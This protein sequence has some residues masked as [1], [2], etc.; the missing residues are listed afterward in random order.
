MSLQIEEKAWDHFCSQCGAFLCLD[1]EDHG[2]VPYR[3]ETRASWLAKEF[4]VEALPVEAKE[5]PCPDCGSTVKHMT[6]AGWRCLNEWH[7]DPEEAS[8]GPMP[9][10]PEP[11]AS[12]QEVGTRLHRQRSI[13]NWC[14]AAFGEEQATS[15]P[16]RGIRLLEEAAEAAQAT[17][18]DLAMAEQ[19]MR[20]V[21]S[22][23]A[24]ALFQELG[25]V[26]VTA[27][28]LAQAAL[29]DADECEA[30]EV[31]RVLSKPLEH[32]TQRNKAKNDAGF[33]AQLKRPENGLPDTQALHDATFE[34][35]W[36]VF[37]QQDDWTFD[38]EEIARAGWN[39]AKGPR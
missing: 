19:M 18:V 7:Y 10:P 3:A 9:T 20:Y 26:G 12:E 15:L 30:I 16:Q 5:K 22:R 24:G 13:G 36:S 37:V 6:Q 2:T 1:N 17:G 4:P 29:L 23:P 21:W 34:Q 8:S 32:F 33:L 27:L 31:E 28:A 25:G 39:A 14:V 35:W 11:V 38:S